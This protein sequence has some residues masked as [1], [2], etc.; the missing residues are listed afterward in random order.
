MIKEM[1]I[2]KRLK[3][4]SNKPKDATKKCLAKTHL[5]GKKYLIKMKF[6]DI[7]LMT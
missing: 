2:N 5:K 4:N 3:L 6:E 1:I 7:N